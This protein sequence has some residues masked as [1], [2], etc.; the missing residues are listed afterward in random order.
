MVHCHG[1]REERQAEFDA[2]F[3]ADFEELG[4]EAVSRH[5]SSG[6]FSAGKAEIGRIWLDRKRRQ[7]AQAQARANKRAGRKA[8]LATRDLGNHLYLA[9]FIVP[10][11]TRYIR[12]E[13]ARQGDQI[14]FSP[15]AFYYSEPYL[16]FRGKISPFVNISGTL[17][18]D[19]VQVPEQYKQHHLP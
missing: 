7:A 19:G 9:T 16:R 13:V 15:K 4:E 14:V 2:G 10:F 3:N 1:R 6:N 12:V 17:T 11:M 18:G 5:L 8:D